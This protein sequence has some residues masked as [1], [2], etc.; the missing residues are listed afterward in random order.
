MFTRSATRAILISYSGYTLP[1]VE[2]C[3]ESLSKMVVVLCTIQ[4][5]VLMLERESSLEDL[6]RAKVQGSIIDK[7]P[8]TEIL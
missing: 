8:F 6:L 3:R 1:A 2:I 5:F 4:E 7:K